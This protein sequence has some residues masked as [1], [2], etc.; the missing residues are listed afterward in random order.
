MAAISN[1]EGDW[2]AP[3]DALESSDFYEVCQRYRHAKDADNLPGTMN[4]S[5]ART[6]RA[7]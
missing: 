3:T 4:A 7:G 6:R 5:R 2:S 1:H